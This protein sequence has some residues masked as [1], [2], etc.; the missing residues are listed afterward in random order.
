MGGRRETHN[1]SIRL[2]REQVHIHTNVRQATRVFHAESV[3]RDGMFRDVTDVNSG[4]LGGFRVGR[5]GHAFK[6]GIVSVSRKKDGSTGRDWK[7]RACWSGEGRVDL[8]LR[9]TQGGSELRY[10][11]I[12]HLPLS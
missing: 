10:H 2:L 4:G 9:K 12:W 8:L 1:V 7:W 3:A 6:L 5:I 11:R